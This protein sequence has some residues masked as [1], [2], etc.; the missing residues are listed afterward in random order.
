MSCPA[1]SFSKFL[2]NHSYDHRNGFVAVSI[3][4]IPS[5]V[6]YHEKAAQHLQEQPR[7]QIRR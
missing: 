7:D 6:L 1:F 2:E 5:H 3:A 4:G